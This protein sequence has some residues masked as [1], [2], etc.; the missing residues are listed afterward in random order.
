MRIPNFKGNFRVLFF[1]GVLTSKSHARHAS[2]L[3][4]DES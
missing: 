3:Y 2:D 4:D 1:E